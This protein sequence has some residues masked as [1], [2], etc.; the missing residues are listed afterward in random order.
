MKGYNIR[1]KVETL[2]NLGQELLLHHLLGVP[3][4]IIDDYKSIWGSMALNGTLTPLTLPC[5]PCAVILLKHQLAILRSLAGFGNLG[6]DVLSQLV[7]GK[8]F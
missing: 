1:C 8:L 3:G 7:P 2:T 6:R 5:L 4:K